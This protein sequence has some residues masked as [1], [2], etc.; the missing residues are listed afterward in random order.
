MAEK[1]VEKMVELMVG[2]RA[3]EWA[4]KKGATRVE[5]KAYLWDALRAAA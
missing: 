3:V 5:R 1:R 2:R 4:E